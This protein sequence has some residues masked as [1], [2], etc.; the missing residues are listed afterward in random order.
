MGFNFKVIIQKCS[1]STKRSCLRLIGIHFDYLIV[2][3]CCDWLLTHLENFQPSWLNDV[4]F[5]LID[6]SYSCFKL[7]LQ[8]V[9]PEFAAKHV[10]TPPKTKVS[11]SWLQA[12]DLVRGYVW[13][14]LTTHQIK[15]HHQVLPFP[16]LTPVYMEFP[17]RR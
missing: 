5:T 1:L 16:A 7:R 14:C 4:M 13:P 17:T 11:L 12:C 15:R 2:F 8:K 9:K 10:P 6:K 3:N